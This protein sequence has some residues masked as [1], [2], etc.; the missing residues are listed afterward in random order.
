MLRTNIGAKHYADQ[1]K[2]VMLRYCQPVAEIPRNHSKKPHDNKWNFY[3][4]APGETLNRMGFICHCRNKNTG[5][6]PG[7]FVAG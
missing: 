5:Q 4:A 1:S 7:V 6:L 2:T 3:S